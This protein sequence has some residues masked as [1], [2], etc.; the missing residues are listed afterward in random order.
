MQNEILV[1]LIN[2]E[3]LSNIEIE[4]FIDQI[5]RNEIDNSTISAFIVGLTA[6]GL[7]QNELIALV[8]AIQKYSL[9]QQE[10]FNNA[11]AC[12]GTGADYQNTFNITTV[13]SIVAAAS[14][15]KIVKKLHSSP[16]N[17]NNNKAFINE[18][19]I[20]I[21]ENIETAQEQFSKHNITF[22]DTKNFNNVEYK[23]QTIRN[24]LKITSIFNLT[25][26]IIQPIITPN[27]F[28]GNSF[29]ELTDTIV[30]SLKMLGYT[31]ALV[32]NAQNPL[33]DEISIC[34]ETSIT[35]L[36]KNKIEKYEITPDS[37]GIKRADILSLRGAT[38]KYNGNLVLDIFNGKIKDAKLDTIAMNAG[39]II[40]LSGQSRNYLEG[41]MKA[42]TTIGKGYA[43]E[44]IQNLQ[45]Q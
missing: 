21:C 18:L 25:D 6:K 30:E 24:E 3:H 20:E 2:K 10:T 11:I 23:I 17:K 5:G 8:K 33:L 35:E 4:N 1:K 22:V 28:M 37:Y 42:Y 41:I 31:K 40:Y 45:K 12:G 44:K 27:I 32:V 38:P 29:P 34:S 13:A 36:N 16:N 14:G 19:G 39:A 15:V 7:V 9:P 43:L 26:A